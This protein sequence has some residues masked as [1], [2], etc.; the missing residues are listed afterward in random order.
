[1]DLD[2]SPTRKRDLDEL[3][4][5][6]STG[7]NDLDHSSV[8]RDLEEFQARRSR[9]NDDHS[10]SRKRDL[11]EF[12]A[13]RSAKKDLDISP[14]RKKCGR[15][16]LPVSCTTCT[17]DADTTFNYEKK[18]AGKYKKKSSQRRPRS[19]TSDG[20]VPKIQF[21]FQN[22]VFM[23]GDLFAHS[24]HKRRSSNRQRPA[25]E[26]FVQKQ[27]NFKEDDDP[28]S[29]PLF[30]KNNSLPFDENAFLYERE[31][32]DAAVGDVL[33]S[34]AFDAFLTFFHS[35]LIWC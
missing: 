12:K 32:V 11:A 5:R 16:S 28:V 2:L 7:K 8:K 33:G 15:H 27:L 23:P 21:L 31:E 30:Y 19:A 1:M 9:K 25:E 13:R 22:Q 29:P 24:T 10:P 34:F 35:V 20:D 26:Y 14:A 18:S 4:A 6:R 17:A 3:Q